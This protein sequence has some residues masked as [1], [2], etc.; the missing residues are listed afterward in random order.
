MLCVGKGLTLRG[1]LLGQHMDMQSQFLKDVS[2]W[3][4]QG[5]LKL[6]ET[7]VQGL[8]RTPEALIGLFRGDNLGKMIVQV[9]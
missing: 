7:V 8:E 2:A 5:K 3:Y 6:N 9:S 4:A 1:Y